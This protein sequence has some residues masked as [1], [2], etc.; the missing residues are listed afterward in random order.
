MRRQGREEGAKANVSLL[1]R[2]SAW[3]KVKD[4]FQFAWAASAKEACLSNLDELQ[5]LFKYF[6][7][8]GMP[9]EKAAEKAD[10]TRYFCPDGGEYHYDP[11]KSVVSCSL[12]GTPES[13][14][15]PDRIRED[16]ASSRLISGIDEI[17][18]SLAFEAEG[19]RTRVRVRFKDTYR[20]FG[21]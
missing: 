9:V 12:H 5:V 14:R 6:S 17:A 2:P 11:E 8:T 15:Q 20:A 13:P 4:D 18:V 10:G 3:D 21:L 7:D 16:T 1:I 19:I